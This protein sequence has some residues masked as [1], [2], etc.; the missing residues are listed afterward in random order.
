MG[1]SL[2]PELIRVIAGAYLQTGS[3]EL[4]KARVLGELDRAAAQDFTKIQARFKT[5]LT[6]TSAD[7][8]EVIPGLATTEEE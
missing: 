8:H 7:V 6:L 4:A 2:R 5:R 1:A 3:W